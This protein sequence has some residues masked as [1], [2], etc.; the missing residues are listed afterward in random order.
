MAR[1]I[2]KTATFLFLLVCAVSLIHLPSPVHADTFT[3]SR[4]FYAS[5]ADAT[6]FS[7]GSNYT[8]AH[9]ATSG[10][11]L[12]TSFAVNT[13]QLNSSATSWYVYRTFIPFDTSVVPADAFNVNV[14]LQVTCLN[15]TG[16][17]NVTV[18]AGSSFHPRVPLQ[19]GDFYYG[20]YSGNYGEANFTGWADDTA[21]NITITDSSIVNTEGYTTIVLRSNNDINFLEPNGTQKVAILTAEDGESLCP[22][23]YVEYE[24]TEF[25]QYYIFGTYNEDGSSFAGGRNVTFYRPTQPSITFLQ[26]GTENN[27]TCEE[28]HRMVF[29]FDMGDNFTRIYYVFA[30]TENIY[31]IQVG[32]PVVI[33]YFTVLDYV[34]VTNAYL[35]SRLNING[36]E[37][38][39][40]RW[41]IDKTTS[42]LP[43]TMTFG[44]TYTIRLVCDQ[45][46]YVF[47]TWVAQGMGTEKDYM[48]DSHTFPVVSP[49]SYGISV[50]ASR[51]NTTWIQAYFNDSYANTTWVRINI[52]EYGATTPL[53][54]QN[55]TTYPVTVNWLEGG[56][57][58]NYYVT[59]E[60]YSTLLGNQAWSFPC[61]APPSVSGSNPWIALRSLGTFPFDPA[62]LPAVLIVMVVGAAFSLYSVPLGIIVQWLVAA[63]LVYLGWLAI[64]WAWLTLAG[65]IIIILAVVEL[66]E[67]E[68]T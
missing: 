65:F 44:A 53:F 6:I 14:T 32:Q 23:L 61:P 10:T 51:V 50:T 42:L 35:E 59:V 28:N 34:G 58:E 18:Q 40:E 29:R 47:G 7:F 15:A 8:A 38:V 21:Y 17:D 64:S 24:T 68:P 41:R 30:Q 33:N 66:K 31:V 1:W 63:L 11:V 13:G 54:T 60:I 46:I 56:T 48:I 3:I 49:N 57:G 12:S 2:K 19:S 37:R 22:K 43:F 36:T 25:Y 20:Y 67:R 9:N 4:V 62:E 27:V 52:T 39:I 16:S 55:T 26:D 5:T 45:G